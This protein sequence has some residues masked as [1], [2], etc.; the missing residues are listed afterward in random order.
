MN[1][2]VILRVLHFSAFD[3]PKVR[4]RIRKKIKLVLSVGFRST[5][6]IGNAGGKL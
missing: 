1:T 5:I 3:I 6:T 2:R 4:R